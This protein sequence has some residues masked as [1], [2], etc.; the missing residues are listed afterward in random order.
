MYIYIEF[1]YEGLEFRVGK[2]YGNVLLRVYT[3]RKFPYTL[4]R[5]SKIITNTGRSNEAEH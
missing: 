2:E 5:T 1:R 3:G 4:R